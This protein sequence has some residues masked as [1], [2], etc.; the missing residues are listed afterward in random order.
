MSAG[1]MFWDLDDEEKSNEITRDICNKAMLKRSSG[2]VK[3]DVVVR[4]HD[5]MRNTINYGTL[6]PD[7]TF[8]WIIEDEHLGSG[9]KRE[10]EIIF[11]D[12]KK[13]AII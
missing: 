1:D 7:G 8:S 3:L 10:A 12:L 11:R 4:A 9:A 2:Y 5:T 13:I 6:L